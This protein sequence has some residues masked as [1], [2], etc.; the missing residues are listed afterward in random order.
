MGQVGLLTVVGSIDISQFWP[1]S[2]GT[3]ASDGDTVRMKVEPTTS[4]L[5]T[6]ASSSPKVTQRYVG[7]TVNDRGKVAKVISA[8]NE[9]RI[10]LQG[11]DCT[12]LHFPVIAKVDESKR[13][14]FS[15]EFRQHLGAGAANALHNHLK[16]FLTKGNGTVLPATFVTQIRNPSDAID[17][18][19]RFVGDIIVG[20]AAGQSINTWLVA[21]GWAL[22]LLYDSMTE[23]EVRTILAAWNAGK[24]VRGRVGPS[25]QSGLQ[26][27]NPTLNVT[28]AKLPD[29]GKVN[30]P[31]IFRRQATF[32]TQVPGVLTATLF[33]EQLEKGQKGKPDTAYPLAYFLK[34]F[35]KL[36]PKKRVRL[37][38]NIGPKGQ[39]LVQPEGLVYREDPS[40]LLSVQRKPVKTW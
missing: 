3:R 16:T 15:N 38:D 27:F 36:D 22:P 11:I 40:V 1:A 17:S 25:F 34:N 12:E 21:S 29:K 2:K 35:N 23:A 9:I 7:A 31:K 26:P 10:R 14:T 33:V 30:F 32:W 8:K 39:L 18:H 4:F 28:N 6:K 13:G 5:F 19:G 37:I 24:K 20:T